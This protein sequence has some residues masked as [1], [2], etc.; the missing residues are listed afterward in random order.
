MPLNASSVKTFRE[1]G[2][3]IGIPHEL[4][5]VTL[6][7]LHQTC[8][9]DSHCL[10]FNAAPSEQAFLSHEDV[11]VGCSTCCWP[12]HIIAW[13]WRVAFC[14]DE[15]LLGNCFWACTGFEFADRESNPTGSLWPRSG[16]ARNSPRCVHLACE[17]L[18]G[19]G[20]EMWSAGVCALDWVL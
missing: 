12:S 9:T 7:E 20:A 17:A 10:K 2:L 1:C 11:T 4:G 3:F 16:V 6:P 15:C 13:C 18:I 5:L 8:F 14:A 19:A